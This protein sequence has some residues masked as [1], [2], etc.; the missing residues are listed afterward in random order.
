MLK[1]LKVHGFRTLFDTEA[2]FDPL[3]IMIGRNGVGKTNILDAL[4]LLGNFARGGVD[5]AFG[6]PPWSLSWQRTKG[7]GTIDSVRFEVQ[8]RADQPDCYGYVL[9]LNER[10]GHP[11]VVEERLIRLSDHS[12]VAS[13]DRGN[14]PLSGT[15]LN[16]SRDAPNAGEID[17]ISRVIRSVVSYEL[18]PSVIEQPNEPEHCYIS[19]EGFGVAGFLANLRDSEPDRFAR[20]EDRLKRFRPETE[21]IDVWSSGKLFWGLRDA[22]QQ[23][24]FQ[25]VHLSWGDRQLVGLLCVLYSTPPG[26]TIAVE[27]IDRGFHHARYAEVIE[28]LSEVAYDG[29]D[30]AGPIQ[31]VITTHSP[32]FVNRLADRLAEIRLVTRVPNGGTIVKPLQEVARENLGTDS[33]ESPIGEIWEAGLLEDVLQETMA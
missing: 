23:H 7:I 2:Q 11:K 21:S 32:S 27:E 12:P 10:S 22:G 14:P 18:N 8:M 30:D 33:P 15:I 13:F 26:A 19:R 29:L 16:P 1:K 24:P 5:R 3:T 25:A 28:L 17:G 4:Q 9:N 6:P 31:V 20:L